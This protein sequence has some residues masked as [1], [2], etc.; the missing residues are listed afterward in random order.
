V[1]LDLLYFHA[2]EFTGDVDGILDRS[3][4]AWRPFIGRK[5]EVYKLACHHEA[6]LDPVPA[7]QIGSTLRQRISILDGQWV[8]ETSPAIG[9][10][11]G[12][13]TAVYV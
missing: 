9:R 2:T 12:A 5:I 1:D 8:P 11:A 10:V 7:A 6:V 13:I 4:S 3:P